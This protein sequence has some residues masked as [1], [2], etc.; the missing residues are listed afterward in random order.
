[1]KLLAAYWLALMAV[2]DA[3]GSPAWYV[4]PTSAAAAL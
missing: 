2:V 4:D 1:M 3:N